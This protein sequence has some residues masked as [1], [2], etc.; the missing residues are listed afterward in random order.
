MLLSHAIVSLQ[1]AASRTF[2]ISMDDEEETIISRFRSVR[3]AAAIFAIPDLRRKIASFF[4]RA[5][6]IIRDKS[7]S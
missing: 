4:I 5:D 6:I 1:I 7:I 2:S 3:L